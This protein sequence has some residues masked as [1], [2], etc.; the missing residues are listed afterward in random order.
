MNSLLN[1]ENKPFGI[2]IIRLLSEVWIHYQK[3]VFYP[4]PFSGVHFY[5]LPCFGAIPDIFLWVAGA[6]D[7]YCSFP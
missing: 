3:S 1:H 2:F 5:S 7:N 6:I 4:Y